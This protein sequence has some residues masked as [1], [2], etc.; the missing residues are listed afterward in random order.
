MQQVGVVKPVMP[1]GCSEL[2][3]LRYF[4]IG[5][6]F[7]EIR[8]AIGRE[9]K[10]DACVSVEPQ[11][12]VNAFRCSLNAGGHLRRKVLGRPVFNSDAFLITGIV[13][14]LF[15]GYLP[16]PLTA[17]AAEF[18]FPNRQNAQ[19][20]VAEHGNIELTS[21]DVL[22]GDGGSSEPLVNERD[23]LC[24]LLVRIDDGRLRDPEGSVLAQALDD[25]R[26][27][28]ARRPFDLSPYRKH[29]KGRHRAQIRQLV[30]RWTGE[31]QLTLDAV[32]DN[33]IWRCRE[34]DLRA[35]GSERKLVVNFTI[36]LTAKTM[37]ALFGPSRRKWIAL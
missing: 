37:Q 24:E 15:G 5:I 31:N 22:F 12:S 2:L 6:R 21:F 26:Q 33:M 8:S 7:D 4:G 28:K 23:A 30:A 20:I 9:A 11:G 17:H 29:G 27:R 16:C 10:V 1:S 19:P 35:P 25:Q 14:G 34:L 36:L 13:F 18:Q 32:L 3:A